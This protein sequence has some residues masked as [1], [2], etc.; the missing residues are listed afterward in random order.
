MF[1]IASRDQ[2]GSCR[3]N[4]PSWYSSKWQ[5]GQQAGNKELAR[6][7]EQGGKQEHVQEQVTEGSKREYGWR[8]ESGDGQEE[9][10][11]GGRWTTVKICSIRREDLWALQTIFDGKK[12]SLRQT[13]KVNDTVWSLNRVNVDLADVDTKFDKEFE[14]MEEAMNN[15]KRSTTHRG[16]GFAEA[17]NAGLGGMHQLTATATATSAM[18]IATGERS[19][20]EQD[21]L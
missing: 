9:E 17:L 15:V 11:S 5:S 21:Y 6:Y 20:N 10:H 13:Y 4:T 12:A 8:R 7:H 2:T 19:E 18:S 1:Y 3:R 14:E 16:Y